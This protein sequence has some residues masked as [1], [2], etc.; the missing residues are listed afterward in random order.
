M[1]RELV[2]RL[3]PGYGYLAIVREFNPVNG[4]SGRE[5][6]RGEFHPTVLEAATRAHPYMV[7][8]VIA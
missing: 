5:I 4:R 3:V 6:Y 2:I 7:M 8:E 1:S